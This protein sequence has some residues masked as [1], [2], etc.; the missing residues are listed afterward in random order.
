MEGIFDR[1]V[2]TGNRK[3]FDYKS[4]RS[5]TYTYIYIYIYIYIDILAR[6][7]QVA[8]RLTGFALNATSC[9]AATPCNVNGTLNRTYPSS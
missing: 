2:L 6:V 8:I 9:T 3:V 7:E 1:S 4:E 5:N